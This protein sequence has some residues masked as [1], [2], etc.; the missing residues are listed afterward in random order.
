[1][2]ILSVSDVITNSSSEVFIV[3]SKP[4]FQDSI[5]EEVPELLKKICEAVEEDIEE[6]L[7]C[8]VSPVTGIDTDWG[9]Y[10]NEKDLIIESINDNSIPGWLMDFIQEI[11]YLSKFRDRFYGY[12]AEDLGEKNIPVY[13]WK[14]NDYV[15]KPNRIESVQRR[16]L[17]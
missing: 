8:S 16:H 7:C 10:Y 11:P 3:H 12:Y 13:D 4:E 5:N 2:K 1:M 15:L 9:Y 14:V 6:M 17:G